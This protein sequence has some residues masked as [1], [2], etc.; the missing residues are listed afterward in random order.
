MYSWGALSVLEASGGTGPATGEGEAPLGLAASDLPLGLMAGI[1]LCL[2][3]LADG[4][5]VYS[6]ALAGRACGA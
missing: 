5:P 3:S 6:G 1:G 2:K 4:A